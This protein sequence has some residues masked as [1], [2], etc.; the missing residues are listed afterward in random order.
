MFF[1]GNEIS[2]AVVCSVPQGLILDA[3][4]VHL[5]MADLA[6]E[7]QQHWL[8]LHAYADDTQLSTGEGIMTI[9]IVHIA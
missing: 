1:Y 5:F 4:P 7:V 8:D 2:S 9:V 3:M 6:D